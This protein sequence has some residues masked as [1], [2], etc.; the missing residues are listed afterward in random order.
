[1][2]SWL[3]DPRKVTLRYRNPL[4]KGV[5]WY[6]FSLYIRQRDVSTYGV[7]ISCGQPITLESCQAGHFMPAKNCGRDLLFDEINVNAECNQCNAWDDTHLLGYSEE[8]DRRYGPGTAKEL[9]ERRERYR[10]GRDG[11]I[12][13]WKPEE[14]AEMIKKLTTYRERL[15]KDTG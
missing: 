4:E 8:L 7:C 3:L 5:F 1:M 12:K 11:V 14:Y 6:Y 10:K 2:R 9:R 15:D 13:D